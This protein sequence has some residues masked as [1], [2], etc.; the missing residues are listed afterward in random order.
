[1]RTK[2]VSKTKTIEI[3]VLLE[4]LLVVLFDPRGPPK[5]YTCGVHPSVLL[6]DGWTKNKNK[7]I[8]IIY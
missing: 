4:Q 5:C 7:S 6:T 2:D 8:Y 1:M 3:A